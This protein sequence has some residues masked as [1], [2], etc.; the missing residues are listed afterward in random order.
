[1]QAINQ[2]CLEHFI[3]FG[4][5]HLRHILGNYET[6]YNEER[7]RQGVRNTRLLRFG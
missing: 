5:A 6:Y 7:A 2:E 4:E 1:M 3:V